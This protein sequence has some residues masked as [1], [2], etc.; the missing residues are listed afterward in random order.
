MSIKAWAIWHARRKVIHEGVFQSPLSTHCFVDNFI[1]NLG[2]CKAVTSE[3]EE[4]VY[5]SF[6]EMDSGVGGRGKINMDA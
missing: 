2:Y 1:S 3:R 6:V 4:G 5:V